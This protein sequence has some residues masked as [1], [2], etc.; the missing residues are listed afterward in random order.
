MIEYF[1]AERERAI[2]FPGGTTN[3][4]IIQYFWQC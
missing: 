4:L 1:E 2:S 3:Y